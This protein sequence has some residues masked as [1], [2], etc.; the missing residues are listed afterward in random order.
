MASITV[1][2]NAQGKIISYRFR[3]CIGRD[4]YGKQN[5]ATKTEKADPNLTPAKEA[6]EM[7]R[8][9]DNW[10]EKLKSGVMST[11]QFTFESFVK[12]IWWKNHVLNGEHKKA[13]I[14]FYK[15]ICNKL[16]DHFGNKKLSNIKSFDIESFLNDLRTQNFSNTTIKHYQNV[17]KIIFGYAETHDVIEKNPMRKVSPVK[18]DKKTVDFLSIEQVKIFLERLQ[19]APLKWQC[20]INILLFNGLRRGEVVGLKWNDIDMNK[21]LL[22]IN[23]SIG[24]T[25]NDGI[26]VNTPKS[27]C[28][29]RTL[30]ISD[31]TLLLLKE[32]YV[33]QQTIFKDY[34]LTLDTYV[35]SNDINPFQPMFP[36][37]PTRWLAKFEKRNNLPNMSPHDLRHTCG[38]LMLSSGA[39]I[40]DVQDFLGHEDAKT[41]LKFYTGTTPNTLKKALNNLVSSIQ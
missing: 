6:K 13:T 7:Q 3:A 18:T 14:E 40:K 22:S 5:F 4:K 24:Y 1:N 11:K 20:L 35:F 39:S 25:P 28:S 19:C 36:T 26:S 31:N 16:I 9:A 37:A 38:A 21:A 29:I 2:R 33:E 15:N 30:P 8:R 32:W 41:T 34:V 23:R 17:L 12:N 10:E 27:S